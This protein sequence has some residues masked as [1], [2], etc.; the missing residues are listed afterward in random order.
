M[1]QVPAGAGRRADGRRQSWAGRRGG[2][3]DAPAA[4]RVWNRC[5]TWN[6]Y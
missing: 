6:S 5:F 2:A 3:D 4:R 1:R